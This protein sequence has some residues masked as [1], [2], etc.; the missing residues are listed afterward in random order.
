MTPP[1][2]TPPAP[3]SA[4]LEIA[5][6][7]WQARRIVTLAKFGLYAFATDDDRVAVTRLLAGDRSP[8]FLLCLASAL[9]HAVIDRPSLHRVVGYHK[10]MARVLRRLGRMADC[11]AAAEPVLER[12]RRLVEGYEAD[13]SPQ[14]DCED[15]DECSE[16]GASFSAADDDE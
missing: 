11:L 1:S 4:L 15:A 5:Q 16:G 2:S 10:L 13:F 8:K 6:G 7:D 3:T 12:L 14:S 9:G